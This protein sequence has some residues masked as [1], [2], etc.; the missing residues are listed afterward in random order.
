MKIGSTSGQTG[1][2]D[3][4]KEWVSK[5]LQA[6]GK[7]ITSDPL[8]RNRTRN[9]SRP[10]W[11]A[12]ETLKELEDCLKK[13]ASGVARK[14]RN[15]TTQQKAEVSKLEL[16]SQLKRTWQN[17]LRDHFEEAMM[18]S[19]SASPMMANPFIRTAGQ[20][21]FAWSLVG[22]ELETLTS[23]DKLKLGGKNLEV[24]QVLMQ[25]V[26]RDNSVLSLARRKDATCF[27]RWIMSMMTDST[28][29]ACHQ[30]A[31]GSKTVERRVSAVTLNVY[32]STGIE[33]EDGSR[34]SLESHRKLDEI[35]KF[36]NKK[37]EED[38]MYTVTWPCQGSTRE[39][40]RKK[41]ISTCL[42]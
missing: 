19:S 13:L 14:R 41:N 35:R 29:L 27:L 25:H 34:Q 36:Y 9:T 40:I 32:Q 37:F 6:T 20:L 26:A 7:Q 4:G 28:I 3:V 21:M 39:P 15:W 8:E 24:Y 1:E 11:V 42:E 31:S 30:R 38:T 5:E 12:L 18:T 10:W 17:L 16:G 2:V 33:K 22:I 23:Y